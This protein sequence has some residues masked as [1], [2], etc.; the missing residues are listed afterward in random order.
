M[1]TTRTAAQI[2]TE[3]RRLERERHHGNPLA[4]GRLERARK[5]N[6]RLTALRVELQRAR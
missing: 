5:I 4:A 2:E 1:T 3:I 6:T